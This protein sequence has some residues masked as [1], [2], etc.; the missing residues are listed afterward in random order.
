MNIHRRSGLLYQSEQ[1]KPG[2]LPTPKKSL[3][4]PLV[5]ILDGGKYTTAQSH[6]GQYREGKNSF[7]ATKT[8]NNFTAGRHKLALS[9]ILIDFINQ[10]IR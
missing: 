3:F 4:Y 6:P 5:E 10:A 2:G 7:S 9:V 8:P 1:A